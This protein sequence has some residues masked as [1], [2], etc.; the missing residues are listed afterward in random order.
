MAKGVLYW[1]PTLAARKAEDHRPIKISGRITRNNIDLQFS[2]DAPGHRRSERPMHV[3]GPVD[4][5][6]V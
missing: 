2:L 5:V 1:T 6:T 3:I 4:R